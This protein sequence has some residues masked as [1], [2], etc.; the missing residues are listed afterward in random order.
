MLPEAIEWDIADQVQQEV[1]QL[2]LQAGSTQAV[3][4]EN[5]RARLQE[6]KDKTMKEKKKLAKEDARRMELHIDDQLTEGNYY[7]ALSEFLTDLSTFPT[8]FLKGPIVKRKKQLTWTQDQNGDWVPAVEIKSIREYTRVSGYDIYPSPGAKTIQDG[9]LHERARLRM[10]D[11]E[12]M[13]GVPGFKDDAIAAVL[14][15]YESGGLRQWLT[16][17]QERADIE[18]RPNE[19]EDPNP[20]L[21][22]VIF[23]GPVR[24]KLLRQW[25]MDPSKIPDPVRSYQ[26]T[27]WL[28]GSW[29]VMARLNPHPLNTRPYYAA[30]FESVNDNIWGRSP[31]E[32]FAD[33][34]DMCNACARAIS[35]NLGIA[36]GPLVEYYKNRLA[37]GFDFQTIEPWMIIPTEDDGNGANNP[38][39]NFWQADDRSAA[40]LKVFEFFFQQ[41]SEQSG[42][43]AYIYGN[44]DVGGAGKTASGLS[45]LMNAA[46]KTLVGVITHIDEKVISASIKEHWIHVMLYDKDVEKSGDINVV[47][48]A[49]QHLVIE[50]QLQLRRTE[51]LE[52]T[53]NDWDR[54]IIGNKGRAKMLQEAFES[55]KLDADG[56]VPE[57]E[58]LDQIAELKA[59]LAQAQ[60]DAAASL[61]ISVE[62]MTGQA[63]GGGGGQPNMPSPAVLDAAGGM[64]GKPPGATMT[65]VNRRAGM[66]YQS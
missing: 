6:I 55:L 24:G 8:A 48:R 49:S 4:V 44:Q 38:A 35:N 40:L 28:I 16:I 56:I 15:E 42:I 62:E 60:A 13:I 51:M 14:D 2:M 43:P 34:Q 19:I 18:D 30:S 53:N 59:M 32:L 61:G 52:A 3:S 64:K 50:E 25:G 36:S 5:I 47:A 21:D 22:C 26:V 46:N 65:R 29:V 66:N 27:C 1:T 23:W 31:I 11:L 41:A 10:M 7:G 45:M 17:D 9:S 20:L 58:E 12:D 37:P 63:P 39:V 33:C 57:P 54:E